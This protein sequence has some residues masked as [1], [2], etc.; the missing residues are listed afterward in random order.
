MTFEIRTRR[1]PAQVSFAAVAAAL[2]ITA[3]QAQDRA[4][5]EGEGIQ[6]IIVTAQR[7]AESLQDVA[8][9]VD[10]VSGQSL[11]ESGVT[12]AFG[13][14]KIS[15]S[16]TLTAGGGNVT[17]IYMRGVGNRTT[18]SYADPA[19]AVSYD[20]VFMGRSSGAVGT[21]FYDLE[22][23]EILK[24]PQG[25]LYGRNATG[26]ALN[27]IPA[28]PRLG[29]FGGQ[30]A[31]SFGNYDAVTAE[32][33]VN[34]PIGDTV[35]VR[36]AATR[37]TRDGFNRDGT[38]DAD[39][40]G[41]RGQLLWEPSDTVSLRIAADYTHVGGLGQG[42]TYEGNFVPDGAGGYRFIPSG[43]DRKE[44]VYTDAANAYRQT[45][46]G[47]PGF[48]FFQALQDRPYQDYDYYG[49]N[50]E[51]NVETGLGTVTLIPAW[52]VG[53]GDSK[54]SV[55]SFNSG[56]TVEKD[57][58]Y[59]LEA[60]L[61]SNTQ[62]GAAIDYILGAY[63]FDEKIEADNT[64]N[65]EFVLPLQEYQQDTRSYALFGQL[66]WNV[67]DR[68]RLIG[69][70]RYTNDKKEMDGI[71]NNFITFCGGLPPANIVPP[72]SFAAGCAAP[73]ALPRYDTLDNPA[74]TLS[75]LVSNGWIAPGTTLTATP[76]VFPLLNGRGTILKTHFPVVE[77]R[78]FDRVTWKVGAE[79][80]AAPDSLIYATVE[81]GYRAGGLQLAEGDPEYEPEILTTFTVGTKNR[82]LD[83]KLQVNVEAFYWK[84]KNQQITYFSFDDSGV[85]I[86]TTNN[87]GRATI[88][89][90]DLDLIYAPTRNTTLNAKVQYLDAVYKD[91]HFITAAPRDNY[92]CPSTLTG[93][94]AGA[95][96][97]KDFN[98]A[99]KRMNY[100]PEW[101]VNLGVEQ[102]VPVGNWDLVGSVNTSWRDDQI[103]GFEYLA[104]QVIDDY[105]STD[106]ALTLR[107]ADGAWSLTGYVRNLEGD[108]HRQAPVLAPTGQLTTIFSAP[109][110]YGLRLQASF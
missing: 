85:L 106:L 91:L 67:S 11:G 9:A 102:V 88:K 30:F 8:V 61:A 63:Y 94:F 109:R 38:S 41:L 79:F 48:G 13:L 50:A 77:D 87:A 104:Q 58:Q 89:G 5:A 74:E 31:V 110:Q 17:S 23:V 3:A 24:G 33:A 6:D 101:A 18:S 90:V 43:F 53:K 62:R 39:S 64:Y 71:I 86:N 47:A 7:R 84:Y 10:V 29:D 103:G 36:F 26:G 93:D 55:V 73:G 34:L 57:T 60:R 46:L 54:F 108:R 40:W 96:P 4:P 65:Q 51:L 76:Q 15:P 99:G 75:W 98:C 81:Q 21:A 95:A 25:I 14:S 78:T 97:V 45:L 69:G 42:S 59:S 105:W 2:S 83:N 28:K 27:V 44:G 52:R 56:W 19:V 72:A 82:F 22:R 32:G 80:D 1:A 92:N 20:G 12:D 100:S 70:A 68:F 107:P 16:I 49:A 66:T 37:V 35:A